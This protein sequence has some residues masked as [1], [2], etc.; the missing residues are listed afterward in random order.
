MAGSVDMI[1]CGERGTISWKPM[2]R[3]AGSGP[4]GALSPSQL[5]DD[6]HDQSEREQRRTVD[7]EQPRQER[8]AAR[9][10]AVEVVRADPECR[11]LVR[12]ELV[13]ARAQLRSE[14]VV[15]RVEDA[16]L[17][18]GGEVALRARGGGV[19]EGRGREGEGSGGRTHKEGVDGSLLARVEELLLED[20]VDAASE[21]ER[22]RTRR[23]RRRKGAHAPLRGVRQQAG[24][25]LLARARERRVDGARPDVDL[26]ERVAVLLPKLES[27]PLGVKERE[28]GEGTH[29][30][31]QDA[32]AAPQRGRLARTE[33][34][35]LRA[36]QEVLEGEARERV[37][38]GVG[39]VETLRAKE[40]ESVVRGGNEAVEPEEA[41]ICEREQESATQKTSWKRESKDAPLQL[42]RKTPR[43]DRMG[44]GRPCSSTPTTHAPNPSLTSPTARARWCLTLSMPP[45]LACW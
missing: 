45:T 38:D 43:C 19:K 42:V 34:G 27:V 37:L 16:H 31:P 21:S 4:A 44:V 22:I 23:S 2:T 1:C 17:A 32:V 7:R 13:G 6:G 29:I 20:A 41:H 36:A 28:K 25:R 10:L 30:G 40:K 9:R 26:A 14:R 35:R 8:L 5:G 24:E 15:D 39:A 11:R 18:R 33:P 12:G 3:S